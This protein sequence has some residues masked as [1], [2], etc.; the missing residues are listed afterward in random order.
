MLL[1][2]EATA[3]SWAPNCAKG[4][5]GGGCWWPCKRIIDVREAAYHGTGQKVM[6]TRPMSK[7]GLGDR[8]KDPTEV[9]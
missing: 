2:R 6:G 8:G 7:I 4:G 9:V 3:G 5:G 1:M